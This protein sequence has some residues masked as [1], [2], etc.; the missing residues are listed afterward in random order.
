MRRARQRR[1]RDQRSRRDGAARRGV[2]RHQHRGRV[3][4]RAGRAPRR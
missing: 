4:S 3:P 2:S 1:Q